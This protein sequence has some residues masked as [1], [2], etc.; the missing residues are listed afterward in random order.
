MALYNII[1]FSVNHDIDDVR[2]LYGG[3]KIVE[4]NEINGIISNLN[5]IARN[6][7]RNPVKANMY[8]LELTA[9]EILSCICIGEPFGDWELNIIQ[10]ALGSYGFGN[11]QFWFNIADFIDSNAEYLDGDEE[12]DD[13]FENEEE[14]HDH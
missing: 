4:K 13:D 8:G 5:T 2:L 11:T 10:T 1:S 7:R 6:S 12:R 9:E 14:E 3:F